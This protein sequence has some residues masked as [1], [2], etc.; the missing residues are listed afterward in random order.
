MRNVNFSKILPLIVF[1][2]L[3]FFSCSWTANSLYV[4]QPDL[5]FVGAWFLAIAFYIIA[6]ICFSMIM[7]AFD[8][9]AS[10]HHSSFGRGAHLFVGILG[11]LAFWIFFSLPTN[12]HN[13]IYKSE[14]KQVASDELNRA[15]EYLGGLNSNAGNLCVQRVMAE[16][17]KIENIYTIKLTQLLSEIDN[18]GDEGFG[19]KCE[20][21]LKELELEVGNGIKIQRVNVGKTKRDWLLA[22]ANIK[23]QC[24]AQLEN[25]R[26]KRDQKIEE[27][28]RN[29]NTEKFANLIANLDLGLSDLTEKGSDNEVINAINNDLRDAYSIIKTNQDNIVFKGETDT[30]RAKER[31]HY[32]KDGAIPAT[33]ELKSVPSVWWDYLTTNKYSGHGFL[34]KIMLSLLVDLAA[35]V[36]FNIAFNSNKNN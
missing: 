22:Y 32:T 16:Y 27:C 7:K 26:I 10:Y 36:F 1:A 12:T 6:S 25:F 8:K 14:I 23:N 2:A 20:Q 18:P 11:V 3:A 29:I 34:W 9:Y 24:D 19:P 28:K 17:D 4:W 5:T 35:F 33:E 21:I 30:E 13:F 15:K 31:E